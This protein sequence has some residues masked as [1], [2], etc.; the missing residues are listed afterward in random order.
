VF[1][2]SRRWLSR[3]G[4][5]A[6]ACVWCVC[7][8]KKA[9]LLYPILPWRDNIVG[10]LILFGEQKVSDGKCERQENGFS[11]TFGAVK[12]RIECLQEKWK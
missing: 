12:S 4:L 8:E 1:D 5:P 9:F 3:V 6:C 11:L 2:F 10:E 7:R